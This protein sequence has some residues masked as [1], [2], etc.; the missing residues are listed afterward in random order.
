MTSGFDALKQCNSIDE[1]ITIFRAEI[2]REG[3]TASACG[4]FIP[5][6]TGP[7]NYFFFVDWPEAWRKLYAERNFVAH[8]YTV[9]EARQ[10]ISPFTWLEAKATRTLSPAER[11]LWNTAN[12]WG[13]GDGFSV[14]IHGPGGYFGLVAMAGGVRALGDDLRRHL[15]MLALAAHDRCRTLKG[16]ASAVQ[17][18]YALT[19]RELECMRWVAAGNTDV[20][21]GAILGL[22]ATT[23][24]SHVDGARKKLDARTRAHAVAR[25]V[26]CGLA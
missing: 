26:L 13:W 6:E 7:E 18:P 25:M 10:R 16:M 15:H 22:S 14:P 3:F 12:S 9:A 8:D 4:A 2:A 17:P 1:L 11:E 23:V 21:I 20:E 19:A 24:K 5:T